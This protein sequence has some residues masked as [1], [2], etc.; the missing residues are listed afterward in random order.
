MRYLILGRVVGTAGL[1]LGETNSAAVG[2]C[3]VNAQS[4]PVSS[5]QLRLPS[6][7]TGG[8]AADLCRAPSQFG[9]ITKAAIPGYHIQLSPRI[10]F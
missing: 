8:H 1:A 7:Q 2:G 6:K 10:S 4:G 3:V 5:A 9:S